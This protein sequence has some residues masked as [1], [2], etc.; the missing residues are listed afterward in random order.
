MNNKLDKMGIDPKFEDVKVGD[1]VF[2]IQCGLG[3]VAEIVDK[4]VYPIRICPLEKKAIFS[5]TSNG[6]Y[7]F[8]DAYPSAW[9]FNPFDP[10]FEMPYVCPFTK[11]QIIMVRNN[12]DK[13]WRPAV[14]K[15]YDKYLNPKFMASE[16]SWMFARELTEEEARGTK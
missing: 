1:C 5:Y 4:G 3:I 6:Q 12:E 13:E 14:F 8:R 2:T 10:D 7:D 16:D 9:T 15:E 11:G